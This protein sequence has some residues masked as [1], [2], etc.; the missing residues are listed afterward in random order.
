[1]CDVNIL[2]TEYL[3]TPIHNPTHQARM[4]AACGEA[5]LCVVRRQEPRGVGG[6]MKVETSVWCLSS[7]GAVR[8]RQN[9]T[10]GPETVPYQSYFDGRKV[11]LQPTDGAEGIL[12]FHPPDW[13]GEIQRLT[14]CVNYYFA[15]ERDARAF[16]SAVFGR[17]LGGAFRTI[18][19]TVVHP[20]FRGAFALEEQFSSME[21]LRLW[22]DEGGWATAGGVMALI[23]ISSSFGDGWARWWMNSSRQM[24]R[25]KRVGVY[26]VKITGIDV[27]VAK[28]GAGA[29]R[30]TGPALASGPGSLQR[31]VDG[32]RIEFK[33]EEERDAFVSMA[34]KAQRRLIALPDL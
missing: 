14:S 32:V 29:S 24:V 10:E 3:H 4:K 19:T 2:R 9:L 8:V 16:Q 34:L 6:G 20:G 23:H 1:L 22:R 11:S 15:D 26:H 21:V 12:R 25:V 31:R 27:T 7:D 13:S 5:R 33:T 17:S 18:K 28:P 30:G